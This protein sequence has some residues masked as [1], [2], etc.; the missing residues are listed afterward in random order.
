[1][2][3]ARGDILLI[4]LDPTEGSEQGKTRPCVVVQNDIINKNSPTTIVIP[5]TSKFEKIYPFDVVIGDGIGNL[6]KKSMLL[7]NQIRVISKTRIIRKFGSLD[8]N[9]MKKVDVAV[10]DVLD[11]D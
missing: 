9:M 8:S 5:F 4:N 3:I 1:M 2:N 10:K 6:V 7:P 11:L